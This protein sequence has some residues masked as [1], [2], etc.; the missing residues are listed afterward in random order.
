M[1]C[2]GSQHQHS[3]LKIDKNTENYKK[4]IQYFWKIIEK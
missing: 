2:L 4:A 1:M 3:V